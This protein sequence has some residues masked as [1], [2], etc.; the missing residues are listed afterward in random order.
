MMT[1]KKIN[2]TL[3]FLDLVL[4]LTIYLYWEFVCEASACSYELRNDFLRPLAQ[5]G[6][7]LGLMFG[8]LTILPPM[9]FNQWFK[10]IFSWGF[11]LSFLIVVM[12][13][14][15]GDWLVISKT[16]VVQLLGMIFGVITIIFVSVQW[17]L[18]KK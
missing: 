12:T 10:Y 17:F 3:L 14:G 1:N 7:S 15:T 16:D 18:T 5:G 6:I 4:L 11:P 2:I 13:R 8:L 9:Y